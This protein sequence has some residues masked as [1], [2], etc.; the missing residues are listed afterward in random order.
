MI[1]KGKI[2]S[3][4]LG[5]MIYLAIT[6]T[7]ILT[8]PGIS[9]NFAR[10]DLWLSPLWAIC[11]VIA[12]PL[13][14]GLN[15]LYPDCSPVQASRKIAG[16]IPGWVFAG[17]NWLFYLYMSGIILREYGEFVVGAFLSETPLLIVLGS[18]VLVCAFAVRGGVEIVGRFAGLFLPAF[19]TLFLLI[20][21]LIIPDLQ[22]TN[23]M[24]IL[25][26][27]I[28]PSLKGS[29][30]LQIWFSELSI[31]WFLLPYVSDRENAKKSL[32]ITFGGIIL[33]LLLSNWVT[34][35]LLGDLTGGYSFP[36]LILARYIDLA[37]FFTHLEALFMAIWVLGAFVKICVFFYVTVTGAAEWMGLRDYRPIVFPMALL[38][39]L[40]GIWIAAN[41][42]EM[43]HAI[44]TSLIPLALTMFIL[45]PA[46]LYAIGRL[47]GQGRQ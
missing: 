19:L 26:E 27:G 40:F 17:A 36:F 31:A 34:L 7:A 45:V 46:I 41:F 3:A 37:E 24:P 5:K 16:R 42:Q 12:V 25:P 22:I 11:G 30:V 15:R 43:T 33:T 4:Q 6:P 20:V 13:A 35:L 10:Q 2:S 18:L 38:L 8:A 47:R 39:T 28:L 1:E 29:L 21:L 14:L 32:W 9:F 44:A 23:M